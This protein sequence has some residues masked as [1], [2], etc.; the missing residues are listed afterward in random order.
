[1]ALAKRVTKDLLGDEK[2][3]EFIVTE[4]SNRVEFLKSNRADVVFATFTVTPERKEVVD[5]A[6][7]YL[8]GALGL[9]RLKPSQL[10]T[11]PS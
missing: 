9:S 6:E 1:M 3:V 2:K 10:L 4:A 5:F 8:K 7:P 11:L